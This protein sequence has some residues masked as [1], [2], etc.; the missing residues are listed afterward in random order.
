MK[1][2]NISDISKY[3]ID[4]SEL[5]KLWFGPENKLKIYSVGNISYPSFWDE[6]TRKTA[7]INYL[8]YHSYDI[9]NNCTDEKPYLLLEFSNDRDLL[10]ASHNPSEHDYRWIS[11][12]QTYEIEDI[13]HFIDIEK[14]YTPVV[15]RI[16]KNSDHDEILYE[17]IF[18]IKSLELYA[19]AKLPWLLKNKYDQPMLVYLSCFQYQIF[20]KEGLNVDFYPTKE[21]YEPVIIDPKQRNALLGQILDMIN[22]KWDKDVLV[23]KFFN[24]DRDILSARVG[25]I[26]YKYYSFESMDDYKEYEHYEQITKLDKPVLVHIYKPGTDDILYSGLTEK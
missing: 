6:K 11:D 19:E 1:E 18:K 8:A 7:I 5:E 10:A 24:G 25:T 12:I 22:E 17:N 14:P 3:D 26:K 13:E 15:I 16:Y 4:L 21:G 20:I 9:G 23:L 2:I